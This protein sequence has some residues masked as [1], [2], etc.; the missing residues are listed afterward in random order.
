MTLDSMVKKAQQFE[1]A[2]QSSKSKKEGNEGKDKLKSERA[3]LRRQLQRLQKS[4]PRTQDKQSRLQ[5]WNCCCRG[6]FSRDC[7]KGKIGNG[8]SHRPQETT[9]QLTMAR[10][11]GTRSLT[12]E[13]RMRRG[14]SPG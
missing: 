12:G 2:R 10:Q 7:P 6:H 3:E 5:C 4:K 13:S 9:K 14:N 11:A 8:F 1:N